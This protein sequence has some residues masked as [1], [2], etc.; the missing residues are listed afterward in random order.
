MALESDSLNQNL[1]EDKLLQSIKRAE[2]RASKAISRLP[3]VVREILSIGDQLREH[4]GTIK[5]FLRFGD[6]QFSAETI[7]IRVLGTLEIIDQ[8]ARAHKKV[9]QLRAKLKETPKSKQACY[10]R[11]RWNLGRARIRL[12]RSV[13]CVEFTNAVRR[14]FIGV[15]QSTVERLRLLEYDLNKLERKADHTKK[16]YRKTIQRDIRRIKLKIVDLEEHTFSTRIELKRTLQTV[17]DQDT[18]VA[19]H[20]QELDQLRENVAR[21]CPCPRRSLVADILRAQGSSFIDRHRDG[22]RVKLSL[23]QRFAEPTCPSTAPRSVGE[24]FPIECGLRPTDRLAAPGSSTRSIPACT[25]SRILSRSCLASV[26]MM[27]MIASRK[28]PHGSR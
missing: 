15:I 13:R 1:E 22:I 11:A 14:R 8:V 4:P 12:S 28:I 10:R 23:R 2:W 24:R 7:E 3:L 26:A 25:R 18:R 27:E 16:E 6:T 20:I 19:A 21:I 9:G 5:D 17:I